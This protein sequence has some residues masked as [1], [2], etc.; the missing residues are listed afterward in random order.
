MPVMEIFKF[1]ETHLNIPIH[2]YTFK[3]ASSLSGQT[4]KKAHILIIGGVHGD[5][6]EGVVATKGLLEKFRQGYELDLH[7]TLVP[8]FNPE[9]ILL[10]ERVNSN[11]VD[12]NRN[13][14]TK[15]WTPVAAKERYNPGPSALSEKENQALVKFLKEN[16][17]D[18]IIS[19]HSWN[20]MLNTNG[21]IPEAKIIA[22]LTGY[23]IEPD[24][25]YPTPGSLGTYAGLENNI[26]TLT[27]EIQKDLSLDQVI[28][29][30]VPAIIEG[31]KE[32]ARIRNSK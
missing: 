8:E 12:L 15:D 1:G 32:S 24:I 6:P 4:G 27:Y 14:P 20:P 31:L 3:P 28:K 2:G 17:V 22:E 16:K 10:H 18:L 7:I 29:V 30:H 26:P 9:G 5:E 19:M 13:L 11:K 23:S 21:D 25:G